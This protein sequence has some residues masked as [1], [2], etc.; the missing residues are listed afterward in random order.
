MP[1]RTKTLAL[2]L[3]H[4]AVA[5]PGLSLAIFVATLPLAYTPLS[6]IF[7][8]PDC[9][10]CFAGYWAVGALVGFWLNRRDCSRAASWVWLAP[11]ALTAFSLP[12]YFRFPMDLGWS[13]VWT[14]YFSKNCG[15]SECLVE[16]MET[17]PLITCVAY[18][19]GALWARR[20]CRAGDRVSRRSPPA[21]SEA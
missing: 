12:V 10:P 4:L 14:A 8:P 19:L 1:L 17:A 5:W 15:G 6:V 11:L 16:L 9:A 20:Q 18:S 3:K 13:G 7:A 2:Y 21:R